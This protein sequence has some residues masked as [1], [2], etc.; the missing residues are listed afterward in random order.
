VEVAPGLSVPV[1]SA[2]DLVVTKV[3]AGRAK[4]LDDVWGVLVAQ[5]DQ[6]D[7]DAVR[8]TLSMLEEALG[9]SDLLPVFNRLLDR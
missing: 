2:E 1:I 6:L 5:S 4:D 8:H 9:V 3:L 7:I